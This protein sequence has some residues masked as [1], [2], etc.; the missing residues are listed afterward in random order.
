M[1]NNAFYTRMIDRF[2]ETWWQR[3]L[4]LFTY[5]LWPFSLIFRIVIMI[6]TFLY[7]FKVFKITRFSVPIIVVGNITV[8]GTGKTPVV[9]LLAHLLKK[10]GYQ[11]GIV[12]RGYGA[13]ASQSNESHLVT[14]ESDVSTV[15]DEPLMIVRQT[16]CPMVIDANRVRAVK[17]LLDQYECDI[18]ISDD[19]LQHTALGRDLEIVLIDG[20]RYF[21]NGLCLPA[22]PLREPI[23]RLNYVDFILYNEGA[24]IVGGNEYTMKLNPRRLR[25]V[26]DHSNTMALENLQG[27][28]IH[29]VAG[30]GHP[31]RFFDMLQ[32]LGLTIIEHPFLDHYAYQF[33]DIDFGENTIVLMTEKD[34]VKCE[35]IAN[36]THWF[37]P[38]IA[39]LEEKFETEFLK[40]LASVQKNKKH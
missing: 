3:R 33:E 16:D 7:R 2:V 6:R 32:A 40:K 25:Q 27:K 31:E 10:Q 12:S 5:L 13:E 29:A 39:D 17:T 4:T 26:N 9:I 38:V 20:L 1:T 11:P 15:G 8:G 14:L 30:I 28:T 19:G 22:G 21:G 24:I 18:V 37:V 34:A 35:K 36:E 23:S